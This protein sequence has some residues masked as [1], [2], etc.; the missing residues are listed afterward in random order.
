MA[1]TRLKVVLAEDEEI[2]L[3]RLQRLLAERTDLV[4]V[5][6][7][8]SG[9][10]TLDAVVAGQA[11]IVVCDIDLPVMNGVDVAIRLLRREVVFVFVTAHAEFALSG[12]D[13]EAADFVLK[14]FTS[15][16]LGRALDVAV[17]RVAALRAIEE[18]SR[19]RDILQ[20][21][22]G[23]FPS[24]ALRPDAPGKRAD[25]RVFVRENGRVHIL[26]SE[27]ISRVEAQGRSCRIHCAGSCY[28]TEGPFQRF[29]DTLGA[30]PFVQLSR[31]VIVN[32]NHI[33]ELQEMFK[34]SLI[35]V[36]LDG[37]KLR[38]SRRNRAAVMDLLASK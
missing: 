24:T 33:R 18:T 37:S 29:I 2:A 20:T 17:R 12:Y 32:V 34:G 25:N 19:I 23:F 36:L 16:R 35:A 14:P 3:A 13:V 1:E 9:D 30:G 15:E 21:D 26:R 38:I 28:Q 22:R 31:S 5:A 7:C 4:V 10:E 8:C 11:D 6:S 27:D